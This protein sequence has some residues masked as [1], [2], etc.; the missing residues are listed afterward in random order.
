[1]SY[2][3]LDCNRLNR[4][5]TIWYTFGVKASVFLSGFLSSIVAVEPNLD[6]SRRFT[7]VSQVNVV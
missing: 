6:E 1:M 2:S 3:K 5:P 7:I 4:S